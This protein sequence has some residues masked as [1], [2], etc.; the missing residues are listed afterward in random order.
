MDDVKALLTAIT[1]HRDYF[2]ALPLECYYIR[3]WKPDGSLRQIAAN[4]FVA[5]Y[6][7]RRQQRHAFRVRAQKE[8]L[9]A[10][11]STRPKTATR[12]SSASNPSHIGQY[13]TDP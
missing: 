4:L 12:K 2:L 6:A 9:I 8:R 5:G 7:I 13:R 10:A 1:H 11:S 3:P